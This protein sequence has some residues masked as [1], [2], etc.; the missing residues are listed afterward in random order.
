MNRWAARRAEHQIAGEIPEGAAQLAPRYLQVYIDDF[1]GA[2]L[3]DE[4]V[5]GNGSGDRPHAH[6]GGRRQA[7]AAGD[8]GA[9]A[10]AAG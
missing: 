1:T 3:D 4:V 10:R 2:A 8:E 6:A 9:R 7:G 5:P